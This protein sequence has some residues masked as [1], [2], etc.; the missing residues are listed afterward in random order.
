MIEVLL[1][2]VVIYKTDMDYKGLD[3]EKD[4]P[5]MYSSV[6]E[7]MGQ[8]YPPEDFGPFKIQPIETNH[9][10]TEELLVLKRKIDKQEKQ[11]KEGY[12]RTKSKIKELRSGYKTAIDKGTR[13]GSGCLVQEHFEKLREIWSGSPSVGAIPHGHSSL[14]LTSESKMDNMVIK[15]TK[16]DKMKKKLSAYQRDIMQLNL[17]REEITLKRSIIQAMEQSS[18]QTQNTIE[19]MANSVSSIGDNIKEGLS[20]LANSFMQNQQMQWSNYNIV[21]AN[22]PT[23]SNSFSSPSFPK[24]L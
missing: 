22:L 20:I 19:A 15:D 23:M 1:E 24:P 17:A 16:R 6:R 18:K 14:N 9:I 12:N 8:M 10:S 2:N 4:L 3:F 13:S 21:H 11:K 5:A 7:M